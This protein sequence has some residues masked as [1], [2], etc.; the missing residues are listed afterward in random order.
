MADTLKQTPLHSLHV[1]LGAKMVDFAGW[2]ME[3]P[4]GGG[5]GQVEEKGFV[6]G[7]L[8]EEGD[9]FLAD[10][11]GEVVVRV[12]YEFFINWLAVSP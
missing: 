6:L 1:E 2:S 4:V 5:E 9:S 3:G 11:I 8:L 7:R 10:R 12:L